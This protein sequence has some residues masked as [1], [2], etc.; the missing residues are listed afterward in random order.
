MYVEGYT[1]LGYR[2]AALEKKENKK[3]KENILR[4]TGRI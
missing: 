3:E 2:F 1:K 4:T